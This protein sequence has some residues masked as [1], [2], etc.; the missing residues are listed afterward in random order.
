MSKFKE[1]EAVVARCSSKEVLSKILQIT[2]E[3]HPC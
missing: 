3:K 1:L 2:P